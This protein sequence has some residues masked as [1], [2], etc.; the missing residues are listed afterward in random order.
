ML[1]SVVFSVDVP[2]DCDGPTLRRSLRRALGVTRSASELRYLADE[3]GEDAQ[4]WARAYCI[5]G[6]GVL[7]RSQFAAFLED[8][9]H[10]EPEDCQTL[11]TLGGPANPYGIAPDINFR[12]DNPEWIASIRVTPIPEC[13]PPGTPERAERAWQRV[14]SAILRHYADGWDAAQPRTYGPEYAAAVRREIAR[15]KKRAVFRD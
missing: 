6:Y 4:R 7:T 14:R 1:F 11:G 9:D 8:F 3:G 13:K 15:A 12:S 5:S 2:A 10:P